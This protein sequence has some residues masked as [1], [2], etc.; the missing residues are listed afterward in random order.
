[1]PSSMRWEE[2]TSQ[3]TS[4]ASVGN[5]GA[6]STSFPRAY[7]PR[8][9]RPAALGG[10][11]PAGS[12]RRRFTD[13]GGRRLRR[14]AGAP[15][16]GPNRAPP[17]TRC[18][19]TA[20]SRRAA[21]P[22]PARRRAASSAPPCA[23]PNWR[24]RTVPWPSARLSRS[25]R[26]RRAASSWSRQRWSWTSRCSVPAERTVGWARAAIWGPTALSHTSGEI[27]RGMRR[28]TPFS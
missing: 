16:A 19:S 12:R 23:R 20:I 17:S 15:R 24:A 21:T 14:H 27:R 4:S 28:P 5:P 3:G 22:T 10:G 6:F 25:S 9:S 8:A 1:M 26:I 7:G 11:S 2:K 13:A 18:G